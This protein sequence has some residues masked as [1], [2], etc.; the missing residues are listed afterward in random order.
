[1]E[2]YRYPAVKL[3]RIES[4]TIHYGDI[5]IT[6]FTSKHIVTMDGSM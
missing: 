3:S 6:L 5:D 2:M 4:N 1:M